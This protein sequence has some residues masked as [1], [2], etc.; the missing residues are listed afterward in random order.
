M[1]E[2]VLIRICLPQRRKDAKFG[3]NKLPAANELTS[4]YPTFAPWRPFDVAQ[5]MLCGRYSET[6]RCAKRTLR[7]PSCPEPVGSN[8]EPCL[9]G[10]SDLS[11]FD[12]GFAALGS[13]RLILRI[14]IFYSVTSVPSGV[15][16]FLLILRDHERQPVLLGVRDRQRP[17]ADAQLFGEFCSLIM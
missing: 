4:S 5:E 6:D 15:N 16:S 8:V 1:I 13:L 14:Q 12:C 9:R 11:Q 10:E 2:D 3:R 17:A 7:K